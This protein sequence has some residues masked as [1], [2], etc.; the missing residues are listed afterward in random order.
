MQ[1]F[2]FFED[3]QTLDEARRLYWELAKKFHPD[4]NPD[5]DGEIMKALNVEFEAFKPTDEKFTGEYDQ[6]DAKDFQLLMEQLMKIKGLVIA[7]CGSWIWLE[8]TKE[9]KDAIKEVDTGETYKRGWSRQKKQWYFSPKG[10]R[11]YGKRGEW[12]YDKI[13][14]TWGVQKYKGKGDRKEDGK[15]LALR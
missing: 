10:Y 12:S 15:A 8:S 4:L 6:W 14:E 11:S 2:N 3:C 7:V 1:V 9:M 5:K 13:K